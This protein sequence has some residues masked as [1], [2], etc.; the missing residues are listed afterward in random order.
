MGGESAIP[1]DIDG[2]IEDDH[3]SARNVDSTEYDDAD[4][5]FCKY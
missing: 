2:C 4:A 3:S 5:F 1:G